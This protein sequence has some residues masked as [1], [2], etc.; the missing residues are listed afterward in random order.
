MAIR[1]DMTRIDDLAAHPPTHLPPSAASSLSPSIPIHSRSP[2]PA[3]QPRRSPAQP[4][5]RL[6]VLFPYPHRLQ[7]PNP[8][9]ARKP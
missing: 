2:A 9:A 7:S 8:A 3:S 6:P 5:H 1:G 4:C